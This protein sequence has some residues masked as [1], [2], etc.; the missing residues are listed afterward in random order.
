MNLPE[1]RYAPSGGQNVAYQ[2]YGD[3]D[4][5]LI[6]CAEFWNSIEAQWMEPRFEAFLRSRR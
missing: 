4:V 2:V 3:G 5:D 6:Y 1:T